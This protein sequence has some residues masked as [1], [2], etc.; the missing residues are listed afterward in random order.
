MACWRKN[1]LHVFHVDFIGKIL[2]VF[3]SLKSK[4]NKFVLVVDKSRMNF[5]LISSAPFYKIPS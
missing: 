4:M 1:C 3:Y 5:M 2:I